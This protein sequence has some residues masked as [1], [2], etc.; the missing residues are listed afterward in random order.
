MI[1][2]LGQQLQGQVEL[3]YKSSGF[4]Y[5]LNVPLNA[6]MTKGKATA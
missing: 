1:T 6:L 2:S 4:V 3:Q 5:T